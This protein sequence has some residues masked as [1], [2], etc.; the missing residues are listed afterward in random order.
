M[1]EPRSVR[2][3]DGTEWRLERRH[4]RRGVA[5]PR[6]RGRRR[7]GGDTFSLIGDIPIDGDLGVWLAAVVA[8]LAIVII[9]IPLLL[10]GLELMLFGVVAGA[11]LLGSYVLSPRWL[12]RATNTGTGVVFE[13][14]VA[15]RRGSAT[16]LDVLAK[17]ISAG[18]E[19]GASGAPDGRQVSGPPRE[20]DVSVA[21][22]EPPDSPS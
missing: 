1:S 3:P 15:G 13:R 8:L 16:A 19:P 5:R 12:V 2:M 22:R 18:E 10:F 6:W 4:V 7:L 20:R 21:P 17:M 14:E 11:V 9:V